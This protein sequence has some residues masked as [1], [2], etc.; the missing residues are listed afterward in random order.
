M[1]DWGS[2]IGLDYAMR[3]EKNCKGLVF[4]EAYLHSKN[5]DDLSLPFQEQII[6]LEKEKDLKNK[7]ENTPFLVEK[8]LPQLSLL[9]LSSH[10][11]EEY[12]KPFLKKGSGKVLYQYWSELPRGDGKTKA[13]KL[14]ESYSEKLVKSK[15]PKL[16]LYSV[17]GFV[18]P[19]S[20]IAWAKTHLS[21]IEVSEA[22][23]ELHYAQESNAELMG[24]T[25]SAWL[26]ALR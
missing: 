3:H 25:I 18:T 8:L 6:A 23:E 19:L 9:P 22:G 21:N 10:D 1:H 17:P 5:T 14:I 26:Q 24:Q 7:I 20:T 16:M 2:L 15:L 13:D 12:R 4:Y 11:M